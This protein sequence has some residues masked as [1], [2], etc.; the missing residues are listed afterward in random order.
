MVEWWKNAEELRKR[1]EAAG[2]MQALADSTGV[3]RTNLRRWASKFNISISPLNDAEIIV[4]TLP[5]H[6]KRSGL[7]T[8]EAIL[9]DHGLDP[10]EWDVVSYKDNFWQVEQGVTPNAQSKVTAKRR[11]PAGLIAP[12]R[13][14]APLRTPKRARKATKTK[15][16][17]VALASDQHCPHQDL[18]LES[19]WLEWLRTNQPDRIINLGDLL[20]LSK[21]SRHRANLHARHNDNPSECYQ[22]GHDWWRR[23]IAAA[24]N[25]ACEF[26]AG[27]HDLRMQIAA[28]ERLPDSYDVKRP[29]ETY[30]WYDLEYLLGLDRLGVTYHRG[31]GEY[32]ETEIMIAP[33][34]SVAHGAKA[35]SYGG[36]AKDQA[37]HEGSRGVGHDHRQ[38]LTAVVRY[39]DGVPHQHIAVSVGTMSRRNLG[40]TPDPDV[41]QGFA[42]LTVWP[43]GYWNVE[44][45]RYDDRREVLTW[46]DQRYAASDGE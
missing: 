8:P 29:G 45:A 41:V 7:R 39:R 9:T 19:C 27:N 18:G 30:A 26:I 32:H 25:A 12:A 4:R 34:F 46:R 35:G 40:Y 28:L 21:P 17:L 2:S 6:A 11:V 14:D 44:L 13:T 15:P 31:D 5:P 10:E 38:A 22:A 16:L 42:T 24:P 20:N 37:R 23:T 43:D 36:A 1:L 33:G 3:P